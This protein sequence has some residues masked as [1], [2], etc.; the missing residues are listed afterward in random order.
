MKNKNKVMLKVLVEREQKKWV[1]KQ[2]KGFKVSEA[3]IIRSVL[4]DAIG[5]K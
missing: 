4:S 5:F 2:A 1:E 3:E